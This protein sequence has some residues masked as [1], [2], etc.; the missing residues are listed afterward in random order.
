LLLKLIQ[1]LFSCDITLF[2]ENKVV[3]KGQEETHD[4]KHIQSPYQLINQLP[5]SLSIHRSLQSSTPQL[6]SAF[7]MQFSTALIIALFSTSSLVS[8]SLKGADIYAREV[9]ERDE[10][11]NF[12]REELHAIVARSADPEE[13]LDIVARSAEPEEL[14][15][16]VSLS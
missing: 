11:A 15:T 9:Q 3:Y 12:A 13:L 2:L 8:A 5:I 10:R 1:L 4:V 16:R 14:L 7:K 6:Y